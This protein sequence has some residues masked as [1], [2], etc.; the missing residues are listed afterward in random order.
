MKNDNKFFEEMSK[1]AGNAMEFMNTMRVEIEKI[2]RTQLEAL[3]KKLDFVKR[4]DFEVTSMLAKKAIE[5]QLHINVRLTKLEEEMASLLKDR[6]KGLS[7]R[8]GPDS[9]P[10]TT[11]KDDE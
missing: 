5:E 3:M 2:A 8:T 10:S 9:G 1:I 11:A 6:S 7:K 4:E